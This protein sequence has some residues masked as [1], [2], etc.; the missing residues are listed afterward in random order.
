MEISQYRAIARFDVPLI[1]DERSIEM[2]DTGFKSNKR[3]QFPIQTF[4]TA[5]ALT[6]SGRTKK[7]RH[8]H[9]TFP[10][11]PVTSQSYCLSQN[12]IPLHS[13]V[14]NNFLRPGLGFRPREWFGSRD[15]S[16]KG[17]PS[18]R[19]NNFPLPCRTLQQRIS[20]YRRPRCFMHSNSG[21]QPTPD[22]TSIQLC[23][24]R[25]SWFAR[26]LNLQWIYL[27]L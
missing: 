25:E 12:T 1:S 24:R 20:A 10:N 21:T 14:S 13:H 9:R 27:C 11:I 23:S 6:S 5:D 17:D 7:F 4:Q 8:S 18:R 3:F 15:L 16:A 19:N 2:T 26:Q 22:R